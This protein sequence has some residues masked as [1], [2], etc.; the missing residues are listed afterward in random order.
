MPRERAPGTHWT[1]GWVGPKAGMDNMQKRKFL[2]PLGYSNSDP[3]VVQHVASCYTDCA[4]PAL[5]VEEKGPLNT[6]KNYETLVFRHWCCRCWNSLLRLYRS[7]NPGRWNETHF[8]AWATDNVKFFTKP[9][10]LDQ[11]CNFWQQIS[12]TFNGPPNYPRARCFW[13]PLHE[14]RIGHRYFIS[15]PY[16]GATLKNSRNI[17]NVR[18]HMTKC[19]SIGKI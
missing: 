3:L 18:D 9:A 2:P 12:C 14:I 10:E 16:L 11:N 8:I 19:V 5:K 4:I 7:L 15:G 1:G 13:D 6:F 17:L